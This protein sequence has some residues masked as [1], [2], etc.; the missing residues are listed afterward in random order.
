MLEGLF[1]IK[2]ENCVYRIKFVTCYVTLGH[3]NA[4]IQ[5]NFLWAF[6]FILNVYSINY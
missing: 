4:P 5:T 2:L 3:A 6:M 1:I